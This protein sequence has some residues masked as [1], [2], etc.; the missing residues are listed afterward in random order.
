VVLFFP[1]SSSDGFDPEDYDRRIVNF[2]RQRMSRQSNSSST[3]VAVE[4]V[5]IEEPM[6]DTTAY[7]DESES[8]A[9]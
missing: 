3:D 4:A 6:V 1:V 8:Y 5:P 7:Y 2:M 9:H